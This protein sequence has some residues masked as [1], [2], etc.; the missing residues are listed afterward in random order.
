VS[1]DLTRAQFR[2][3]CERAGFVPEMLGYYRLPI[4]DQHIAVN[5]LNAGDRRRD[6]LAYLHAE[7]ERIARREAARS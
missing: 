6:R 4:P 1:R 7:T 3:A 2:A 5:I